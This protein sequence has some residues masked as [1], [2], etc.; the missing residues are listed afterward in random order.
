MRK[1]T[2]CSGSLEKKL[3]R[4]VVGRDGLLIA[5][6]IGGK[7]PALHFFLETP[8]GLEGVGFEVGIG[9]DEFRNKFV[10]QAEQIIQDQH[11]AIAV[12]AC[13]NPDGGD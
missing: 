3:D 9:L 1:P 13:P 6:L 10:K 12:G 2:S 11:L 5:F 8:Q 4:P 7:F